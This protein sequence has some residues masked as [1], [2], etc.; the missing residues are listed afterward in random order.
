METP[1]QDSLDLLERCGE[2]DEDVEAQVRAVDRIKQQRVQTELDLWKT[3]YEDS[4]E[5][6]TRWFKKLLSKSTRKKKLEERQYLQMCRE[7]DEEYVKRRFAEETLKQQLQTCVP[8]PMPMSIG[9]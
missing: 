8:M 6:M 4:I 1:T 2:C 9:Q 7:F 3:H 5:R